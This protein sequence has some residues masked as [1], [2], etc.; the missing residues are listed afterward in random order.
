[1]AAISIY[2]FE[3]GISKSRIANAKKLLVRELEEENKNNYV[4][5]V[6]ENE[7]SYDVNLKF[8]ENYNLSLSNCECGALSLC[9]HKI[10]VLSQVSQRV[11]KKKKPSGR[12]KKLSESETVLNDL[13]SEEIKGW[14]AEFFKKNK[15]AELQFL[16]DFGEKKKDFNAEDARA[17]IKNTIK[18][19]IGK[20]KSL[21]AP[22]VKKITDLLTK[23]LDPLFEFVFANISK[24][25]AFEIYQSICQEL[26][27]FEMGIITTS[28]RIEKFS[29]QLCEKYAACL[30]QLRD[31]KQWQKLAA[32]LWNILLKGE[33][34]VPHYVYSLILEV[35]HS[36]NPKQ[37]LFIAENLRIQINEWTD[38]SVNI[39]ENLTKEFLD[40]IIENDMFE[41][42]KSFFP[43]IKFENSYNLKILNEYLKTD[44]KKTEFICKSIIETNYYESFNLP[45]YKI[46][47]NIYEKTGELHKLAYIKKKSFDQNPTIED[48]I[49][50]K[51]NEKDPGEFAKFRSKVLGNL[52]RSFYGNPM[53]AEVY[54]AILD[55]E[56]NY[57][58]MLE[59]T[60]EDVPAPVISR[61]IDKL[62][63]INKDKL[64]VA[65][66]KRGGWND[67]AEDAE[68][69][70]DFLITNYDRAQL[71]S[72]MSLNVWGSQSSKFMKLVLEKL[73]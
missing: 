59:V 73:K 16:L 60:D 57:K 61:Y 2:N 27:L 28:T 56:G 72:A 19:V 4:A 42:T 37:K 26:V 67:D 65:L 7:N 30:N 54:F 62:F 9:N 15:V 31:E 44:L 20:K 68:K 22:E 5:F 13:N 38:C 45:Y 33:H 8:N 64:L 58:K 70:V 40:I 12:T 63:L 36:A 23:A 48:F 17:I 47:E 3:E 35:Y 55:S 49:F 21:T 53:F 11:L 39:N 71:S 52:R 41:N 32:D 18:S 1:M 24:P 69:M 6:D 43:I 34:A 51:E 10:A 29:K 50:I 66:K 46:L 25:F 14:L